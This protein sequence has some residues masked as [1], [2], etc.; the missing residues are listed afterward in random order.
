[1]HRSNNIIC[2][3]N[4]W[5]RWNISANVWYIRWNIDRGMIT[6]VV[7]QVLVSACE[8]F[9]CFQTKKKKQ[10]KW[11]NVKHSRFIWIKNLTNCLPPHAY[12]EMGNRE[13]HIVMHSMRSPVRICVGV[14]GSGAGAVVGAAIAWLWWLADGRYGNCCVKFETSYNF[15]NVLLNLRPVISAMRLYARVYVCLHVYG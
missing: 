2:L 3:L 15:V 9:Y 5:K 14:V 12:H 1:M 13:I 11:D 10:Q 6:C 8:E 4:Q 7:L